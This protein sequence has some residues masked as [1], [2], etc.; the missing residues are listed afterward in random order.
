MLL[1][2]EVC[3]FSVPETEKINFFQGIALNDTLAGV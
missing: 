2:A 3:V 1:P